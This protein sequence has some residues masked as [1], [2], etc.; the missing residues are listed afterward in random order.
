M[1]FLEGGLS[2]IL[3]ETQVPVQNNSKCR[4]AYDENV[5]IIDNRIFC[6]GYDQGGKDACQVLYYFLRSKYS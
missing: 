2:K 5:V 1:K 4:K 6:A 3:R